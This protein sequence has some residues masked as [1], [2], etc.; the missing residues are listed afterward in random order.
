MRRTMKGSATMLSDILPFTI[1]RLQHSNIQHLSSCNL[2]RRNSLS[3]LNRVSPSKRKP[4]NIIRKQKTDWFR[5]WKLDLKGLKTVYNCYF[6]R[7][8]SSKNIEN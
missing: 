4:S 1:Y 8:E 2:P 3:V 6:Y 7:K 5:K